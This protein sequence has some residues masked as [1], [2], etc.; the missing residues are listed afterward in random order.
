[1]P[2][3]LKKRSLVTAPARLS[4]IAGGVMLL[5][6]GLCGAGSGIHNSQV[7]D[8]FAT[9]GIFGFLGGFLLLVVGIIW[10]VIA[11]IVEGSKR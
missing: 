5:G 6:L 7:A 1:M 9:S 8:V 11:A 4:A 2:D 10:L 3:P